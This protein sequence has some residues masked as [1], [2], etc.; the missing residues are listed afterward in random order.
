[1]TWRL[2]RTVQRMMSMESSSTPHLRPHSKSAC[3]RLTKW[4]KNPTNEP[5]LVNREILA[6]VSLGMRAF[7]FVVKDKEVC[8]M[9]DIHL[10]PH[11]AVPAMWKYVLC[12][13][14]AASS[15][16]PSKFNDSHFCLHSSTFRFY[17]FFGFSIHPSAP[18][19]AEITIIRQRCAPA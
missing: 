7:F 3:A 2:F 17:S 19:I 4:N 14:A 5:K 1:M 9:H 13:A 18:T 12:L 11:D 6:I 15:T 16:G 8:I 10:L